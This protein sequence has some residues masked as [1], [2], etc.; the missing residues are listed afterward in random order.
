MRPKKK[1]SKQDSLKPILNMLE[2]F[3]VSHGADRAR[4]GAT[5]LDIAER[6]LTAG[7]G[8]DKILQYHSK[9][10][11]IFLK[12]LIPHIYMSKDHFPPTMTPNDVLEKIFSFMEDWKSK[13]Y[14]MISFNSF[15]MPGAPAAVASPR[16]EV[17]IAR[18]IGLVS[19]HDSSSQQSY[20]APVPLVRIKEEPTDDHLLAPPPSFLALGQLSVSPN[21]FVLSHVCI[22]S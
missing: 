11:D 15:Q 8:W 9:G 21:R 5:V 4:A 13:L 14:D 19:G 1:M 12:K 18:T 10:E 20:Q 7:Y 3:L 22:K 6:L 17:N 16:A 2:T